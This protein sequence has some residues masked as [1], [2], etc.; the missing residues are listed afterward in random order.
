MPGEAVKSPEIQSL[1]LPK[2]FNTFASSLPLEAITL[3]VHKNMYCAR[4]LREQVAKWCRRYST[5]RRFAY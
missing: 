4:S 1:E 2:E 5:P 3:D